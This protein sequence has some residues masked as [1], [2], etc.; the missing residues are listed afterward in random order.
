MNL[1]HGYYGTA[2]QAALHQN[3]FS[4]AHELLDRGANPSASGVNASPLI[5]ACG[6]ARPG[7]VE[8]VKRLIDL[9]VDLELFDVERPV[10][11]RLGTRWIFNALH[12]AAR[13]G[14]ETVAKMLLDAGANS[15]Y[16][17]TGYF[18]IRF[19]FTPFL[20]DC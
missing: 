1:I 9:E 18:P 17:L 12:N 6:Y 20:G 7:Q 14:N 15:A 3:Y 4:L 13:A 8:F 19:S 10:D 16:A 5:T 2:L 11:K